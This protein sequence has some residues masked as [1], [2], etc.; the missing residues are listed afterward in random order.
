MNHEMKFQIY[1]EVAFQLWFEDAE[2]DEDRYT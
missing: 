1:F 2:E